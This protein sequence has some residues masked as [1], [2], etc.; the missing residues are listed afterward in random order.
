MRYLIL[1]YFLVVIFCVGCAPSDNAIQ[2]FEVTRIVERTL[3]VTRIVKETVIITQIEHVI[4]TSTCKPMT[5]T[6]QPSA[7]TIFSKW[8][9]SRAIEAFKAAG[10]EAEDAKP[11]TVDDY[12]LAPMVAIEGT[13]FLIPSICPDCG[14][15]LFSFASAEELE[16]TRK[17]YDMLGKGSAVFFSWLF[18]K[19]NLLVQIN[20]DLPEEKAREYE[21]VLTSLDN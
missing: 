19:D 5:V 1:P 14:G 11:M 2:T 9:S 16:I 10:L 15:R 6:P 4:V 13:R 12:G 21:A 17:Y 20:G 18:V 7:T 8:T 3:E